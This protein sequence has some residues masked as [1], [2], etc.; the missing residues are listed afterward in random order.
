MMIQCN[1]CKKDFDGIKENHDW[2]GKGIG[3]KVISAHDEFEID[4]CSNVCLI[5]KLAEEL[6]VQISIIK[7]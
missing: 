7:K 2:Y 6:G 1:T 4:A 5:E 3:A